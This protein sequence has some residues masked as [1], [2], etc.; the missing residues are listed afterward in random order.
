MN[1]NLAESERRE[2]ARRYLD[3]AEAWLRK[4][5]DS[6]LSEAFGTNYF[7]H[8]ENAPSVIPKTVR[9]HVAIRLAEEPKRFN[10]PIDATTFGQ[11]IAIIL[12]P[13]IYVQYF[14]PALVA[15]YPDRGE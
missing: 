12:H 14:K 7:A 2:L 3:A 1:I 5:I 10:R 13:T 6:Q 15:A 4:I 9:E 11:N 8:S